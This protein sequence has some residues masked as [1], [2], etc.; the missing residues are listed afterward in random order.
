MLVTALC[1][2]SLLAHYLTDCW[3]HC[4]SAYVCRTAAVCWRIANTRLL[5]ANKQPIEATNSTKWPE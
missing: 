5:T 3:G 2:S 4:V 1:A